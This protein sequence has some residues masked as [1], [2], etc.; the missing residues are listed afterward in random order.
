MLRSDVTEDLVIVTRKQRHFVESTD[1]LRDMN[2]EWGGNGADEIGVDIVT[3]RTLI[4]VDLRYFRATGVE[5]PLGDA[6]KA[7]QKLAWPAEVSCRGPGCE[8]FEPR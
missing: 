3:G 2:I 7:R 1:A 8:R 4:R 5:T 6:S